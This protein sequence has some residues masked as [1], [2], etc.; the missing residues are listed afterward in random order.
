[1]LGNGDN[2]MY[3]TLFLAKL[4]GFIRK[5]TY[6]L[7]KKIT[8]TIFLIG[9][10]LIISL[11]TVILQIASG[12]MR[13]DIEGK[14]QNQTQQFSNIVDLYLKNMKNNIMTVNLNRNVVDL[15]NGGYTPYQSFVIYRDVYR[16]LKISNS[17]NPLHHIYIF[18]EHSKNLLSSDSVNITGNYSQYRVEEEDWYNIVLNSSSDT[19]LLDHFEPPVH[20]GGDRFALA[21]RVQNWYKQDVQGTIVITMEKAYFSEILKDTSYTTMDFLVIANAKGEIIYTSNR[22]QVAENNIDSKKLVEIVNGSERTFAPVAD[23]RYLVDVNRSKEAGW[24]IICFSNEKVLMTNIYRMNVYIVVITSVCIGIL[25]ILSLLISSR[26]TRPVKRLMKLMQGAESHHYRIESKIDRNDEIGDLSHCFNDMV[27]KV[28]ENQVL[29]KEAEIDALQQQINPHFLYN[30]LESIKTLAAMNGNTSV[31]SM[32]QAL[33]DMF[34]YSINRENDKVVSVQ[35]EIQHVDNYIGIQK[36]RYED[37]L[38]VEYDIDEEIFR[39][40]TLKFILQPI[41]ENAIYHGIEEMNENGLIRIKA[42][43]DGMDIIFEVSDNG[44]GMNEPTL[45]QLNEYIDGN[46]NHIP[47]KKTQS[48]GLKNIQER[49][50]LFFGEEY[51]LAVY[52]G[53]QEGTRVVLKI[54]AW[55]NR[56]GQGSV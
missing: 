32:A 6:G 24:S 17:T 49:I 26:F 41:V 46:L 45:E 44:K 53:N 42:Y 16:L 20:P 14:L 55:E 23:R 9:L 11:S 13:R 15:M 50:R 40:H 19:I 43:R 48:I 37:R 30:T 33:G 21:Y 25:L 52:K 34:R 28:L 56:G 39:F 31:R 51:G 10:I 29:R 1:M 38:S 3:K 22:E 4:N 54:P 36:I 18:V 27:R 8:I 2:V 5:N 35:D 7:H 12:Y 47:F